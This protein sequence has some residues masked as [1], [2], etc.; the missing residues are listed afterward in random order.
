M[1]SETKKV[2]MIVVADDYEHKIQ[3]RVI[4]LD[5]RSDLLLGQI[6]DAIEE[7]INNIE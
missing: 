4:I 6:L 2:R 7:A 3:E 1:T 5:W